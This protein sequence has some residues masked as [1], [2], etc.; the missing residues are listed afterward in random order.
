M[1][2]SLPKKILKFYYIFCKHKAFSTPFPRLADSTTNLLPF[3]PPLEKIRESPALCWPIAVPHKIFV[4]NL[5][6]FVV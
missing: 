6:S 3:S 5:P 4:V 2:K 1:F